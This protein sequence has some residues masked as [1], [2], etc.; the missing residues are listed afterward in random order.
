MYLS[1]GHGTNGRVAIARSHK[2]LSLSMATIV[3]QSC[4]FLSAHELVVS[5]LVLL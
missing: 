3:A 1:Y 2:N 5:D 4:F